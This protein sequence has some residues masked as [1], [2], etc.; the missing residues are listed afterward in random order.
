MGLKKKAGVITGFFVYIYLSQAVAIMDLNFIRKQINTL[1]KELF[2]H[3]LNE[4][5]EHADDEIVDYDEIDLQQEF[6]KLNALLFNNKLQTPVLNWGK[7]KTSHGHV[8]ATR[9][10]QTG[11]IT[12]KALEISRFSEMPYKDFKD[13]LAHEMIHVNLLQN[14]IKD[15]HGWRFQTEMDRIN[16]MG[17]GFNITITAEKEYNLSKFAPQKMAPLVALLFDTDRGKNNLILMSTKTYQNESHHIERIMSNLIKSGKYKTAE[18]NYVLTDNIKLI[19]YKVSRTFERGF[20]S[21]PINEA[22]ADEIK[23]SGKVLKN[24][25][26][27]QEQLQA[28]E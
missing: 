1:L 5:R 17:L 26:L 19:K 28:A 21:Y 12:I 15:G 11:A 22:F 13:V 8:S 2:N 3:H 25:K 20:G 16:S 14:N 23:M 6:A 10:R 18:L 27:P 4:I 24:T 9:N 7:R